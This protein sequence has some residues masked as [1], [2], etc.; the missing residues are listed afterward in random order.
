V[1]KLLLIL[2]LAL[3]ACTSQDCE[4]K[5]LFD[6]KTLSGWDGNPK[7]WS[8]QDGLITGLTTAQ[9]P[10]EGNTFIIYTAGN[11]DKT[12]VEFADF[13]AKIQYRIHAGNSGVQY[14]SF[15]LP[16]ANDGW[17]VGG[18]QADFD[19][20]K[21]WAGTNYG[22]KFRGILAKR[23]EKAEIKEVE[24]VKLKNGKMKENV[25]SDITV[26]ASPDVLQKAILDAPEWNE[27][28][29]IA[30]GNHLIQKINGVL[31]SEVIDM[32]VK[33]FRASGLLAI[34][35]HAGPPMKIEVRSV[36]LKELK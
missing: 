18:Y 12:P 9:T 19:F 4:W 16:G 28:H 24:T 22:E 3:V 21:Q 11:A 29:I 7:F 5:E 25:V 36:Q 1:K 32:D 15:K 30:K 33:N 2:T 14:R 20:A 17:R 34:Q 6:G 10:T 8:V 13:E 31:M 23:G 26:L 35:L 27:I